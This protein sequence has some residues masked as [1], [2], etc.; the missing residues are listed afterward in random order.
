M[1]L[2]KRGATALRMLDG[3]TEAMPYLADPIMFQDDAADFLCQNGLA[4]KTM[5][6]YFLTERGR[7]VLAVITSTARGSDDAGNV[8]SSF[9]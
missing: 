3:S 7:A 4:A 6:G 5:G 1:T 9:G 2:L 8:R